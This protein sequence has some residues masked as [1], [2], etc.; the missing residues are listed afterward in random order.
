M[1]EEKKLWGESYPE[2]F[3]KLQ[4]WLNLVKARETVSG[5]IAAPQSRC[6]LKGESKVHCP[7]GN[8]SNCTDKNG[9]CE[10]KWSNAKNY[11]NGKSNAEIAKLCAGLKI[12]DD[13]W[14]QGSGFENPSPLEIEN[15]RRTFCHT[16]GCEL[17]RYT[18]PCQEANLVNP[19][20]QPQIGS[21]SANKSKFEKVE[22]DNS[23][24]EKTQV[25]TPL[26]KVTPSEEMKARMALFN[27]PAPASPASAAAA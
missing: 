19:D 23:A 22:G 21:V 12:D 24:A 10:E 26:K 13:S 25:A 1:L 2:D 7:T 17:G 14:R 6:D 15:S 11:L 3:E 4:Q 5:N 9:V 27:V 8:S 16:F 18:T 20:L